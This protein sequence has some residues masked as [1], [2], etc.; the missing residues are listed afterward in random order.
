MTP[1]GQ[2]FLIYFIYP[3]LW[4][5]NTQHLGNSPRM[6]A[7][8]PDP[9]LTLQTLCFNLQK[10]KEKNTQFVATEPSIKIMSD[11]YPCFP[12]ST[13]CPPGATCNYSSRMAEQMWGLWVRLRWVSGSLD[14][15]RW[16]LCFRGICAAPVDRVAPHLLPNISC[17]IFV[18][19]LAP[20]Q[21]PAPPGRHGSWERPRQAILTF[22]FQEAL[23]GSSE[24]DLL[25]GSWPDPV[26][27]PPASL[28]ILNVAPA[29]RSSAAIG[30][31]QNTQMVYYPVFLSSNQTP[32]SYLKAA[33]GS[34]HS[35]PRAQ[36]SRW[37]RLI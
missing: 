13:M 17:L 2:H 1:I 4:L 33:A 15:W 9:T 34:L 26:A 18:V 23:L 12:T 22:H 14:N 29:P 25:P 28:N 3:P 20:L 16:L 32:S 30:Q 19:F 36:N 8:E 35:L 24:P 31:K 5:W 7:A 37:I 6:R 21:P 10:F 11:F 27:A